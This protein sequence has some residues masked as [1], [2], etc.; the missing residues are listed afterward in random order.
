MNACKVEPMAKQKAITSYNGD[1]FANMKS[2]SLLYIIIIS[3]IVE[4]KQMDAR[5]LQ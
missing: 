4:T 2:D 1:M 5:W 3:I